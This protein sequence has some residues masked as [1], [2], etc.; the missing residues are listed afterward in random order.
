VSKKCVYFKDYFFCVRVWLF[1]L[2]P[3]VHI[4]REFPPITLYIDDTGC[5]GIEQNDACAS[6]RPIPHF[7]YP[8]QHTFG[9]ACNK[10]SIKGLKQASSRRVRPQCQISSLT[11]PANNHLF[12]AGAIGSGSRNRR[13]ASS[14]HCHQPAAEG[15]KF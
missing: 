11:L 2:S 15:K 10:K 1:S 14:R 8:R 13:Q 7:H 12:A 3:I 9:G 6:P 5:C 4:K